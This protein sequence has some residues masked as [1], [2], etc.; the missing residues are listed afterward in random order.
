MAPDLGER[1]WRALTVELLVG[2]RERADARHVAAGFR[3]KV[4]EGGS[5]GLGLSAGRSSEGA[6]AAAGESGDGGGERESAGESGRCGKEKNRSGLLEGTVQE[7]RT[8]RRVLG[9]E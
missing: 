7:A 8:R 9:G 1:T 6:T 4:E 3:L 5:K 2:G